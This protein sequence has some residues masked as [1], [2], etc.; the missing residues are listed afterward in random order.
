MTEEIGAAKTGWMRVMRVL[1]KEMAYE[2]ERVFG[3]VSTS[4]LD[5]C[6]VGTSFNFRPMT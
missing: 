1:V 4:C 3:E 6:G 2:D 5:C